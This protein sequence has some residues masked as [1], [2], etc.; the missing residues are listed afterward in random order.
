MGAMK[1][2]KAEI[3]YDREAECFT[4]Y[5]ERTRK[6]EPITE[7]QARERWEAVDSDWTQGA[8]RRMWERLVSQ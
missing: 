5:N 8:Y 4:Q 1:T 7:N 6:H 2:Q 3:G